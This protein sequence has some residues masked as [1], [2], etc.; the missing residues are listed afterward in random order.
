[1]TAPD[2]ESRNVVTV[3][4]CSM[5]AVTI[6]TSAPIVA[7]AVAAL[8]TAPEPIFAVGHSVWGGWWQGWLTFLRLAD[9]LSASVFVFVAC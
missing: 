2:H 8:V 7:I 9:G 3:M 4:A 6:A 5:A 1:M